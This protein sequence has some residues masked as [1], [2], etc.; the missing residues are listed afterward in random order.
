[1]T[2]IVEMESSKIL[3]RW[4]KLPRLEYKNVNRNWI[5]SQGLD[6]ET[7]KNLVDKL[8]DDTFDPDEE[9]K[10]ITYNTLLHGKSSNQ[11]TSPMICDIG[12]CAGCEGEG[13]YD[14]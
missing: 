4:G 10:V 3:R 11:G 1:M 8:Y 12:G 7:Q 14:G 5:M 6:Y 9:N 2:Y 13:D